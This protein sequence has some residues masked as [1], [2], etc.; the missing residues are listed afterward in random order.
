MSDAW[1]EDAMLLCTPLTHHFELQ[2][3]HLASQ[4]QWTTLIFKCLAAVR[5]PTNVTLSSTTPAHMNALFR[6]A[7]WYI[8]RHPSPRGNT[9]YESGAALCT[10]CDIYRSWLGCHTS[11]ILPHSWATSPGDLWLFSGKANSDRH[12]LNP[13]CRVCSV[14]STLDEHSSGAAVVA[15]STRGAF[16]W[17][18]FL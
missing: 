8:L 9:I 1:S 16:Q 15:V 18:R 5:Y 11:L 3:L 14:V 2:C 17:F 13:G 10:V 6:A 7:N 4:Q 12:P